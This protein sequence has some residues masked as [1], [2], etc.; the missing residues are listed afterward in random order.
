MHPA[1]ADLQ[2][3]LATRNLLRRIDDHDLVEVRAPVHNT[4]LGLGRRG[5]V[6]T[7][8]HLD[9]AVLFPL[10]HAIGLRRGLQR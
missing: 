8:D 1:G 4:I 3:L 6:R 7:E 2:A 5:P 9:A 10:E